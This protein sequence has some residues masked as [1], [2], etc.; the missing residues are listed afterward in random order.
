VSDIALYWIRSGILS[1]WS[2]LRTEVMTGEVVF[3]SFSDSTGESILNSLE[4]I[5]FSGVYVQKKRF[6]VV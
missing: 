3:W 5:Y 2:F 4:A 6:A 1:Q